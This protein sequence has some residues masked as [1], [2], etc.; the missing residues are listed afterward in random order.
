MAT[1]EAGMLNRWTPCRP[2]E[3]PTIPLG[4]A[5]VHADLLLIHPFREGNGRLARW[6][7]DLMAAQA[8]MSPPE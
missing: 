3:L 1:F 6:L 7:A 2:D 8:G 4:I 5:Q